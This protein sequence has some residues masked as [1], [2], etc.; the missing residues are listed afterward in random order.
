MVRTNALG[1]SSGRVW[2]KGKATDHLTVSTAGLSL[3]KPRAR[4]ERS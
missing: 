1:K 3:E 4:R 2:H